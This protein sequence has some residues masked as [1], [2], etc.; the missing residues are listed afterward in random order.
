MQNKQDNIRIQACDPSWYHGLNDLQR[1]GLEKGCSESEI[2]TAF[3]KLA[4]IHHP[5]RNGD[6]AIFRELEEAYTR[7]LVP[8]ASD[9]DFVSPFAS[10]AAGGPQANEKIYEE[11][12]LCQLPNF[13]V[14]NLEKNQFPGGNPQ[15]FAGNK[16]K[17]GLYGCHSAVN[18]DFFSPMHG[19][20]CSVKKKTIDG[21]KFSLQFSATMWKVQ[22][23]SIAAVRPV[24]ACLFFGRSWPNPD[25]ALPSS[26][27]FPRKIFTFNYSLNAKNELVVELQ[28]G[29][30]PKM[31]SAALGASSDVVIP[32]S[33]ENQVISAILR[34]VKAQIDI[35]RSLKLEA[36]PQAK[37]AIESGK[38][39]KRRDP[40]ASGCSLM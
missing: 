14:I 33:N 38:E 12:P 22:G 31:A 17:V 11:E 29:V 39:P 24:D 25:V 36:G 28:E 2:K 20:G 18:S 37:Q 21:N 1:L 16:F 23:L 30:R 27:D 7:L 32:E 19:T 35:A 34:I 6:P 13:L 26:Q 40:G 9:A 5:D 10:A 3:R 8:G 4:L 15:I